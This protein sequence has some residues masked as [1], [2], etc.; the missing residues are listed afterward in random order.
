MTTNHPAIPIEPSGPSPLDGPD[1]VQHCPPVSDPMP[2]D[3]FVS[4]LPEQLQE[5]CHALWA[6]LLML[7]PEQLAPCEK[8]WQIT[9]KYMKALEVHKER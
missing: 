6:L 9:V 2:V 8:I 5:D 7:L 3:P 1:D 4:S